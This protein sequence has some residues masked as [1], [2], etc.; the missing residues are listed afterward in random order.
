LKKTIT[1]DGTKFSTFETFFNEVENKLTQNLEWKIGRN[2]DAFNDILCGGFGIHDWDDYLVIKWSNSHKSQND[3]GWNETIKYLENKLE[4]CDI[5]N[6]QNVSKDLELAQ[7]HI[8]KTLYEIIVGII[9]SH[10]SIKLIEL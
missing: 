7:Q 2:L 8:G 1:L 3:L 10:D 5:S 9:K 6:T 4:S